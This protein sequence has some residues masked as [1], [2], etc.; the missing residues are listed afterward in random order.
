MSSCCCAA[1]VCLH[2]RVEQNATYDMDSADDDAAAGEWTARGTKAEGAKADAD[3]RNRAE[4]ATE[5]FMLVAMLLGW[6][7]PIGNGLQTHSLLAIASL[8]RHQ[9]SRARRSGWRRAHH[10]ERSCLTRRPPILS[11]HFTHAIIDDPATPSSR[12][13]PETTPTKK[14][15]VAIFRW[16]SIGCSRCDAKQREETPL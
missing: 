11:P 14:P 2:H 1:T 6:L 9:T 7:S 4:A 8:T 16:I 10:T 13:Q 15:R 5:N 3:A 12:S